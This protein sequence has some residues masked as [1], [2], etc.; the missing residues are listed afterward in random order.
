M[1][2]R[3]RTRT[4]TASAALI[5]GLAA[6]GAAVAACQGEAEYRVSFHAEW[7]GNS[8]TGPVPGTAHFSPMVVSTH[9]AAGRTWAVGGIASDGIKRVAETGRT[10]SYKQELRALFDSGDIRAF[11]TGDRLDATGTSTVTLSAGADRPLLTMVSMIAPSPDWIVGTSAYN[12]CRNDAWTD[13]AEL[14]LYAIDAGTDSGPALTSANQ[15]TSPYEAIHY[16]DHDFRP[17][18]KGTARF[19][20]LTIERL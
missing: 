7:D 1:S 6:S 18:D 17:T 9:N 15:E 10:R 19:G 13:G 5:A 20:R 14:P 3:F 12:L 2:H 8:H 11:R 4:L 16:L